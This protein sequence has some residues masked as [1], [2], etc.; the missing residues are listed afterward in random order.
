MRGYFGIGIES[1]SKQYNVGALFRSAH[2]F[3]AAFVFTVSAQYERDQGHRTD[4]SDALGHLPFYQFPTVE[5][6]ILPDGCKLV[7]VELTEKSIPLPS[8]QHP[9]HAAYIM[10]PERG[11]LSADMHQAC[12][13]IVQIP[14]RFCLNVGAAGL[15]VMYDRMISRGRFA[16]RPLKPGG[17]SE[18]LPPHT[19]GAPLM[20]TP[21]RQAAL[22]RHRQ[23]PPPWEA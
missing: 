21:E 8:F 4:T 19:H 5:Q 16:P 9:L 6:M 12:D 7:G 14:S 2:A 1:V 15:I 3:G 10:G 11:S 22:E 13:F 23:P 20:R 18:D 17:P